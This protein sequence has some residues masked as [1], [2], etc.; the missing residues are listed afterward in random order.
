M[1]FI[2]HKRFNL[3]YDISAISELNFLKINF[4]IHLIMILMEVPWYIGLNP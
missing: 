3:Y 4:T 2:S 1:Y